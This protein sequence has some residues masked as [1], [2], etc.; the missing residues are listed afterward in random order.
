VFFDEF[1]DYLE[2]IVMCPET[3]LIPE[4]FNFHL[5]NPLNHDARKFSDLET[6]W[7]SHRMLWYQPIDVATPWIFYGYL[8][9]LR[10][11]E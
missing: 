8:D 5:N 1:F 2:N 3:L 11:F 10:S 9:I 7:T 4:D 6:F